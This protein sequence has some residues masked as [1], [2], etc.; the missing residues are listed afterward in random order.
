MIGE[1]VTTDSKAGQFPWLRSI[2]ASTAGAVPVVA[3]AVRML[4]VAA[5]LMTSAGLGGCT[6]GAGDGEV[7]SEQLHVSHCM[8]GPFKLGPTFFVGVPY[9]HRFLMRIQ[10][11]GDLQEFSDGLS[12]LVDD[13]RYIEA[14][15]G[16][17]IKVGLPSS[18]EPVAGELGGNIE[19]APVHLAL[20]LHRTCRQQISTLYALRGVIVFQ[21]IFNGDPYEPNPEKRLTS[22]KFDVVVGDPR[23]SSSVADDSSRDWSTDQVNQSQLKGWFQFYFE[24]GQPGQPFP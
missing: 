6:M 2:V 3:S 14:N 12:V 8:N 4:I 9:R 17:P 1:P 7:E 5:V 11:G 13:V 20:Y 19:R 23:S 18:V 15:L 21:S 24:R 16:E 22:A 10:R